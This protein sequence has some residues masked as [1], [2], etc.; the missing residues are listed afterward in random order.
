MNFAYNL[1]EEERKYADHIIGTNNFDREVWNKKSK[2]IRFLLD[3]YLKEREDIPSV[4]E[5]K[6]KLA[7][8]KFESTCPLIP[9]DECIR[10]LKT[11]SE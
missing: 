9:S 4:D 11:F 10:L 1:S 8:K 2:G 3:F 6:K 5:D 7:I